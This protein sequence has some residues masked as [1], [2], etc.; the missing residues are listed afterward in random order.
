M[1]R[2]KT[3]DLVN[4]NVFVLLW[5]LTKFLY[6]LVIRAVKVL[7]KLVQAIIELVKR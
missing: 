4:D 5:K 7:V 1:E 3:M 6:R 2:H